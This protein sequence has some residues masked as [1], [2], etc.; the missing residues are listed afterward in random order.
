MTDEA[1][2]ILLEEE[3]EETETETEGQSVKN[4]VVTK[5]T[6]E[7][8]IDTMNTSDLDFDE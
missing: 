1:K 3:N 2:E 5:N 4:D 6:K 8:E 7:T